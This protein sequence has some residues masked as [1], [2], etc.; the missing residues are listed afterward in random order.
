MLFRSAGSSDCIG[1]R[2]VRVARV[3]MAC[4]YALEAAPLELG[5]C[6]ARKQM[7]HTFCCRVDGL[8]G[9]RG[10]G[11]RVL[12]RSQSREPAGTWRGLTCALATAAR[13]TT[14]KVAQVAL[15]ILL[16]VEGMV[17][18]REDGGVRAVGVE[19]EGE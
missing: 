10:P 13:A 8:D 11:G 9:L 19:G 12:E 6:C 2:A 14:Q 16:F 18:G 4:L 5:Q 15:R 17:R 7:Q 3:D 1:G